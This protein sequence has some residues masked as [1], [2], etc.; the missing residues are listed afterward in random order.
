MVKFQKPFWTG[1]MTPD[2]TEAISF[3]IQ[4]LLIRKPFAFVG[5]GLE[6]AYKS[7][8]GLF[9]SG[10]VLPWTRDIEFGFR[11]QAVEGVGGQEHLLEYSSKLGEVIVEI[12][13]TMAV[14]MIY[15]A[16]GNIT[17]RHVI[18]AQSI[19]NRRLI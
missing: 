11:I 10:L 6:P 14:I 2:S 19:E 18:V 4:S 17:N 3:L 8:Q 12:Y 13:E 15:D 1:A 7:H 5:F 16:K 9:L